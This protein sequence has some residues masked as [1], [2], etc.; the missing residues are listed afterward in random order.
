MENQIPENIKNIHSGSINNSGMINLSKQAACF[1]CASTFTPDQIQTHCDDG[2]TCLCPKC[3][4]DSVI[5]SPDPDGI[6]RSLLDV[7]RSY[8]FRGDREACTIDSNGKRQK[9]N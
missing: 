4:I 1:Q 2:R 6:K 3:G 9:L 5:F 7:M 8:Y